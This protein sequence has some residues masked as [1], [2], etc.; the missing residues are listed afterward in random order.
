MYSL[1]VITRKKSQQHS[2]E[3]KKEE[4]IMEEK[5]SKNPGRKLTK[6]RREEITNKEKHMGTQST[7]KR[8]LRLGERNNGNS[9]SSTPSLGGSQ[10]PYGK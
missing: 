8:S 10:N 3:E 5:I 9:G 4:E 7:I 2:E 1:G 6:E